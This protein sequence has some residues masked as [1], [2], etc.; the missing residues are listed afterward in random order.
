MYY[1]HAPIAAAHY[2]GVCVFV[3]SG[4]LLRQWTRAIWGRSVLARIVGLV[5]C[6]PSRA[7][8]PLS[9]DPRRSW[10]RA[11]SDSRRTSHSHVFIWQHALH[12]ESKKYFQSCALTRSCDVCAADDVSRMNMMRFILDC[13]RPARARAAAAARYTDAWSLSLYIG[14]QQLHA[15]YVFKC[16]LT[17]ILQKTSPC[18]SRLMCT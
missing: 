12:G 11:D 8:S 6:P 5:Q 10:R 2:S 14:Y 18:R 9:R 4:F 15:V 17:D 16:D 13:L 3:F 1:R 7:Q